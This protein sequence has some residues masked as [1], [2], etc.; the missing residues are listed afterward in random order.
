VE[1]YLASFKKSLGQTINLNDLKDEE[2][3]FVA[4]ELFNN[5]IILDRAK[6]EGLA[7]SKEYSERLEYMK[8]SLLITIFIDDLLKK[9]VSDEMIRAKYDEL[10]NSMKDKKEYEVSY[11]YVKEE[12]EINQVIRELEDHTFSEVASNYS[13]DPVTRNRGGRMGGWMLETAFG[14][15]LSE[16]LGKLPINKLSKPIKVDGGW[17]VLLKTGERNAVIPKFEDAKV[18]LKNVVSR[19]FLK[20]YGAANTEKLDIKVVD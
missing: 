7:N 4:N 9:N 6:A 15:E 20:N 12:K 19:D 5:K 11:I 8:D 2:K 3:K 14:S 18:A 1:K 10:V 17:Y 13:Q 16:V